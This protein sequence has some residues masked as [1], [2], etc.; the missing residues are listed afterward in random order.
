MENNRG[1]LKQIYHIQLYDYAT[2][3]FVT[4][5]KSFY[6]TEQELDSYLIAHLKDGVNPSAEVCKEKV[7]IM[8]IRNLLLTTMS[9]YM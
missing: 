1:S 7:S 8:V 4:A 3:G 9:G 2:P 5:Y 6:G